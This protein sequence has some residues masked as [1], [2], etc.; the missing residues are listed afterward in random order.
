[1]DRIT[2]KLMTMHK[3]LYPEDDRYRLYES[4][5]KGV[6]D[7]PASK[8]ALMH[9]YDDFIKK[10]KK[11]IGRKITAWIFQVTNMKSHTRRLGNG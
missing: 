11:E 3:A 8:I 7:S 5:K 9:P 1:M 6:E 2:R 4:K 10:A